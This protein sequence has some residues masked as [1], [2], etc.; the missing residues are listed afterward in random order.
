MEPAARIIREMKSLFFLPSSV[1]PAMVMAPPVE[2]GET[3]AKWPPTMMAEMSAVA[4]TPVAV[5]MVGMKGMSVGPTTP[6]VLEKRLITPAQMA[7]TALATVGLMLPLIQL[8][9]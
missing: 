7:T 6:S 4:L 5:A 3:P 2:K 1:S 8:D 9:S